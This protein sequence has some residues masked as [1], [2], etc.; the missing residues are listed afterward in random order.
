MT[1]EGKMCTGSAVGRTV[2]CLLTNCISSKM[3]ALGQEMLP[4]FT[5]CPQHEQSPG[6]H[7][8]LWLRQTMMAE[9]VILALARWRQENRS[10]GVHPSTGDGGMEVR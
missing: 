1:K 4:R 7:L 5:P 9:P 2:G 6:F 10:G 8:Q 3:R